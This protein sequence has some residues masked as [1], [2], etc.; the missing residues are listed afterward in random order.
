MGIKT[1][2][3]GGLAFFLTALGSSFALSSGTGGDCGTGAVDIQ[4]VAASSLSVGGF[5]GDQLVNAAQIMNAAIDAGLP[6]RAQ[7]IG[8]MTAIGES[9]L[10]NITFGDAIHGVINPD[11]TPTTS[12]GLFQQ[13]EGWG[14]TTTRLDPHRSAT[15]FFAHLTLVHDWETLAPSNAA[16]AVQRNSNPDHYTPF[17]APAADI[18]QTLTATAGGGGCAPTGDAQALAQELVAHADNGTLVGL[19]PDHIKEI[20]WI[21]HGD[22]VPGCGIDTNILQV[23]VIAVRNFSRVGISDINRNCTGQTIG[24]GATSRHTADGGG[25]AVDFYMLD[26][27]ALTGFDG[28][29]IRLIGLLDPVMP[30]GSRVGQSDCRTAHGRTLALT[31]LGQFEDRCNHLHVDVDP[32]GQPL[33]LG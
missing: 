3:A 1:L 9:S 5:S 6:Q 10:R 24:A 32:T 17:F 12:I 21:A 4:A 8:V 31:N 23:I 22:T 2:V 29:S 27:N 28:Q 26:S 20:R 14:S 33:R 25:H 16:H 19:V 30:P 7:I 11:G 13:Q 18:V 15:L